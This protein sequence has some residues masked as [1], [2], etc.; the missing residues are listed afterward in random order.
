MHLTSFVGGDQVIFIILKSMPH[1][2]GFRHH[3]F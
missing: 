2:R 3:D 1:K